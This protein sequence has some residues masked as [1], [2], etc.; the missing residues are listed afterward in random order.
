MQTSE[1]GRYALSTLQDECAGTPDYVNNGFCKAYRGQLNNYSYGLGYIDA[2]TDDFVPVLPT[3][4]AV[5]SRNLIRPQAEFFNPVELNL[6]DTGAKMLTAA[7][8]AGYWFDVTGEDAELSSFF[9]TSASQA[10]VV[11]YEPKYPLEAGWNATLTWLTNF[12]GSTSSPTAQVITHAG[13]WMKGDRSVGPN[14]PCNGDGIA[15]FCETGQDGYMLGLS[16]GL[17]PVPSDVKIRSGYYSDAKYCPVG[18]VITVD[19][20]SGSYALDQPLLTWQFQSPTT[21]GW[22]AVA[23]CS[24]TDASG[25]QTIPIISRKQKGNAGFVNMIHVDP[26]VSG[27]YFPYGVPGTPQSPPYA[28]DTQR[29]AATKAFRFIASSLLQSLNTR[30]LVASGGDKVSV[31]LL[32]HKTLDLKALVVRVKDFSPIG[33]EK[34]WAAPGQRVDFKVNGCLL[35][36]PGQCTGENYFTYGTLY[37]ALDLLAE[38][39]VDA[40]GNLVRERGLFTSADF[41]GTMDLSLFNGYY[42]VIYFTP[43]TNINTSWWQALRNRSDSRRNIT[44]ADKNAALFPPSP[45]QGVPSLSSFAPSSA[46]IGTSVTITGNNFTGATSVK[47]NGLAAAF[48]VNSNTQ[49]STT[50]PSGATTG[51]ISITTPSGTAFS[52][53]VFTVTPSSLQGQIPTIS[54][55]QTITFSASANNAYGTMSSSAVQYFANGATFPAIVLRNLLD[56]YGLAIPNTA[57]N[58]GQ[59]GSQGTQPF[60]SPRVNFSQFNYCG[61]GDANG[62]ATF[63]GTQTADASCSFVSP[64]S[65]TATILGEPNQAPTPLPNPPTGSYTFSPFLNFPTGPSANLTVATTAPLFAFSD[66]PA[67][68]PALSVTNLADYTNNKKPTRGNPIQV[69]VFFGAIVPA[70]NPNINGS[71]SPNLTTVELCKVFD[72]QITNFNQIASTASLNLP[73]RLSVRSDS[74]G[75]TSAF[76][77]YLA[78]ACASVGVVTPGFTGYYITSAVRL[79]PLTTSSPSANFLRSDGDDGMARFVAANSGGFGYVQSAFTKPI[80]TYA[81]FTTNPAP[82]QVALQN[83]LSGS[84]FTATISTVRNAMGNIGL[85]VDPTYPCILKVTGLP[86]VPTVGTAYPI[87]TQ[88]YALTY[89]NYPTQEQV[90]AVKNLFSFILGN[91]TN[92]IQ[93]NDQ[94]VG[95]SG[96]VLL[97]KGT[98]NNTINPLRSQARACINTAKVA[99]GSN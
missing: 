43:D 76:T 46:P 45:S 29:T 89:T 18:A 32:K 13:V 9:S 98:A 39:A 7:R 92:P 30:P 16:Y 15:G 75:T 25:S 73:I 55:D 3:V 52:T 87:V 42:D 14:N 31:Q 44:A 81:P 95:A 97:G 20:F 54:Q 67:S 12:V 61:T 96:L 48:V 51:L 57:I 53:T 99:V 72:G 66:A 37:N 59:I 19:G 23:R 71:V 64:A 36:A 22:T 26:E 62:V 35:G 83:P 78:S 82:I 4:K 85:A 28:N 17:V 94:I 86:V 60:N 38:G 68:S 33:G 47:I 91:R 11:M 56:F 1:D 63:T 93:A 21:Y 79:F 10:S 65:G 70:I 24:F 41:P 40:Q 27:R 77:S 2:K 74:S 88:T 50:V 80:S 58:I 34:N 8:D 90:N 5:I 49:I 84:F 69:P 6:D